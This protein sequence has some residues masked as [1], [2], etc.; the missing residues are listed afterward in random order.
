MASPLPA[1]FKVD[2]VNAVNKIFS[3]EVT[4][5]EDESIITAASELNGKETEP[6]AGKTVIKDKTAPVLIITQPVDGLITNE[7]AVDIIGTVA[8]EYFGGLEINEETVEV[9]EGAFHAEKLLQEG[10]NIFNVKAYD[11]AG[12]ITES[13]VSVIVKKDLP[14]ITDLEPSED[15]TLAPGEQLTVSFRS[16][17]GGKGAF[18]LVLPSGIM[19]QG[20]NTISME[21]AEEGYYVGTW[22]APE[23]KINGLVVE[24]E[25]TDNAGN[26]IS[27]VAEGRVHI[28]EEEGIRDL[29]PSEDITLTAGEVLT[30][31]FR[32][33]K[34]GSA[35]FR[36]VFS[37]YDVK[38]SVMA[39]MKEVS[40][41]YYA[42][43]WTAPNNTKANGL[44]VEVTYTDVK[45]NTFF[46][47][48][49]GSV[50]VAE[51]DDEG[52]TLQPVIPGK[53][54]EPEKPEKPEGQGE[55]E[56][57]GELKKP[58]GQEGPEKPGELKKPEELKKTEEPG[59]S[60]GPIIRLES[61]EIS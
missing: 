55:P 30:V 13:S 10:E 46:A 42:G 9:V 28:G 22:T 2:E 3:K 58:E 27:A 33:G 50:N 35:S 20:N 7:R 61:K 51:S 45:G 15:V 44:L 16:E 23:A 34:G 26:T 38:K 29:E 12:N 48:A 24:A 5:T 49:A 56:K 19:V 8:D 39:S 37:N 53:P 36:L 47:T 40:P 25:F 41:G 1:E 32:S 4:L 43:T 54:E 21:E 18:R 57:P 52:N 6:S 17:P 59:N 31:S 11:L 14:V 60:P